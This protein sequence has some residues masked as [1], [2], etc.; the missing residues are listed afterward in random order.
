MASPLGYVYSRADALKRQLYDM[1]TNPRDYASMLGGRIIEEGQQRE[2]LSN[3][4]FG[5]PSNPLKITNKQALADLTD[6]IMQGEMG[7]AQLGM[8]K[9]VARTTNFGEVQY[10]PR[11][12][13]RAKEQARIQATTTKVEPT[14]NIGA[15]TIYLPDYEGFP[16]ITSMSDRTAG[17]G[18][19]TSINDVNLKRPV[20]LPG[21]QDY[22]FANPGQVWAS[23]SGPVNQ[24]MDRA[25][26]IRYAT[27]KDPLYIPWRMAPTGGDFATFTGETMLSYAES[28]LP[29]SVKKSMDKEIKKIADDWKGIDSPESIE[30]FRSLSDAKRKKIKQVLDTNFRD[31]GSL[32]IG[33]TRLAVADPNQLSAMDA[34]IMNVG[35][36]FAD[37]PI[38][39]QSGHPSYPKG[40]PGEGIGKVDRNISI[41]ELL[42]NVVEARG[43]PSATEPRATDIR[44]LQMKP[45]AGLLDSDTL[46]R[47]GY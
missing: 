32:N 11:F 10:D 26:A 28:A 41:F 37:K 34:G 47:L 12:D 3:Q 39:Q 22:M 20:D 13:P 30:Q 17:G 2:N 45:Y 27:G 7:F 5:D 18:L 19:L 38:I 36:I 15:P 24:I 25:E 14:A 6:K 9:P 33:Q 40:V 43:I 29:K 31:Q 23:G 8:T 4:A 1:I 35:R 44:A 21:G 42:P 16:F 46:K